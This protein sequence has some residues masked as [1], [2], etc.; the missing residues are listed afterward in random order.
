MPADI[1]YQPNDSTSTSAWGL[2]LVASTSNTSFRE[3]GRELLALK[4]RVGGSRLAVGVSNGNVR[5]GAEHAQ[6]GALGRQ[7][8]V[9]GAPQPT[10]QRGGQA[11]FS[12]AQ[13]KKRWAD[14][15]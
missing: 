1:F 2:A 7:V 9:H 11:P 6:V 15:N 4:A 14:R 3:V 13:Q 8:V 12:A 10:E 5:G